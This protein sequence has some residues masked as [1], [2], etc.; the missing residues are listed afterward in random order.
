MRV[1]ANT[2]IHRSYDSEA[3]AAAAAATTSASA[4]PLRNEIIRL[5][6]FEGLREPRVTDRHEVK[7]NKKAERVRC[8]RRD[9]GVERYLCFYVTRLKM[10]KKGSLNFRSALA[11]GYVF[12]VLDQL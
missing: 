6:S 10:D 7:R 8:V 11:V 2:S 9:G 3:A 5:F 4:T 12:R 1:H